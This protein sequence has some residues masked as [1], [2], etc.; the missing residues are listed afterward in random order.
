MHMLKEDL[1]LTLEVLLKVLHLVI[2]MIMDMEILNILL[3]I[4]GDG[5][6]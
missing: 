1:I 2:Q 4:T 3:T 6:S 5:S